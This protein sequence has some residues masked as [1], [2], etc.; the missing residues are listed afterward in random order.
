MKVATNSPRGS[1]LQTTSASIPMSELAARTANSGE[2]R[3]T[4][5]PSTRRSSFAEPNRTPSANHPRRNLVRVARSEE[6]TSELQSRQYLVCR[7]LLE[8][9]K[10]QVIADRVRRVSISGGIQLVRKAQ[11]HLEK[12]LISLEKVKRGS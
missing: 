9:K 10:I 6:H 12:I 2:L 1:R 8:K 3:R 7:L 11:Q 5:Q 4:A